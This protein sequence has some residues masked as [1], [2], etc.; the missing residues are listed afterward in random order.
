MGLT[1]IANIVITDLVKKANII[2]IILN[3]VSQTCVYF[4]STT[5]AVFYN[6]ARKVSKL[7]SLTRFA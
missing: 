2:F 5:H 1:L 3:I 4:I 7:S 6:E